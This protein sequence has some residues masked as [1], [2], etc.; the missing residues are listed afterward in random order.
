ML[1]ACFLAMT[2]LVLLLEP[3]SADAPPDLGGNAALKY[4]QAFA[5]LPRLTGA[6]EKKLNEECVTMPL[7]A[8]ARE[9]VA[10]ADYALKKMRD[11][12][13]LPHCEWAIGFEE[14]IFT[15]LP[16]AEGPA[17]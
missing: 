15:R 14:G 4:W 6:E 12:A 13:A 2:V 9:M 5:A 10:K 3:A 8:H 7:D 11:G 1:R 17:P 16:H